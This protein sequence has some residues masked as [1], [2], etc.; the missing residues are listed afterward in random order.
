MIVFKLLNLDPE[1]KNKCEFFLKVYNW[2]PI[3]QKLELLSNE[4]KNEINNDEKIKNFWHEEFNKISELNT[5]DQFLFIF[6]K[7]HLR[8]LLDRLDILSMASSVEARVPFV[9][10]NLVELVMNVPYQYKFKWKSRYHKI[11]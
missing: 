5:H 7:F 3:H 9:D 1:S 8:C 4:F 11:S 6:Q 2:I 10:H